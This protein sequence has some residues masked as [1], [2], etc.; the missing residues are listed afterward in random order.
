MLKAVKKIFNKAFLGG[1]WSV[2]IKRSDKEVYLVQNEKRKEYWIADPFL[3]RHNDKYYLFCEKYLRKKDKGT[4]G[5]FEVN[6]DLSLTD[7]GI[8]LE[9]SHHLSYPHMFE[10]NGAI[11]MIPESSG[12]RSIDLYICAEFPLHWKKIKTLANDVYAVDSNT[13]VIDGKRYLLTYIYREGVPYL[14][15]YGFDETTLTLKLLSECA[16]HDNIG[17]GAGNIFL[18]DNVLIRPTQNQRLKYGESVF[19]NEINIDNGVCSESFVREL[20]ISDIKTDGKNEYKRIHTY[21][22]IDD[23]EVVDLRDEKY[24][25]L[26]ILK[27]IK[28]RFYNKGH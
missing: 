24:E 26:L 5:A 23:I 25:F 12:A 2:A 20:K 16:Y 17:R 28:R 6:E 19:F 22:S 27:K 4:I 3:Y 9:E 11:Y 15:L 14:S 1:E 8:V 18:K 7:L 10:I 21:N 13:F